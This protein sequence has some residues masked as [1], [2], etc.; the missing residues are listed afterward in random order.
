MKR[1]NTIQNIE[2]TPCNTT[3]LHIYTNLY[4]QCICKKFL[5]I[6]YTKIKYKK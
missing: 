2:K 6:N 5:I 1:K 4:N 3:T